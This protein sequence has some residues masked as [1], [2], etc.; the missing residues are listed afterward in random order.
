MTTVIKLCR[1]IIEKSFN[2]DEYIN[3]L[4]ELKKM[5]KEAKN[6]TTLIKATS[7]YF[8]QFMFARFYSDSLFMK[9]NEEVNYKYIASDQSIGVFIC[10]LMAQVGRDN[11]ISSFNIMIDAVLGYLK[12]YNANVAKSGELVSKDIV[13]SILNLPVA[14]D[15]IFL[16]SRK[17]PVL[18]LNI[19][20]TCK[21]NSTSL[22]HLGV[23]VNSRSNPLN[24]DN[25]PDY[26]FMHEMGHLVHVYLTG[27][28][29]EPP[30][31]FC[32]VIKN[33]F[34][35]NINDIPKEALL[36]IFA[37]CFAIGCAFG[38]QYEQ[39]NP[40][41]QLFDEKDIEYIAGYIKTLIKGEIS[42]IEDKQNY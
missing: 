13:E 25:N 40:F 36:E 31:S 4:E 22:P 9:K 37:D 39:S 42:M 6:K 5:V 34:R 16:L 35:N 38:T 11:K 28:L 20:H 32:D 7:D 27:D 21:F 8:S 3:K 30:K 29:T 41:C 12:D 23:I 14:K 26:V 2:L 33:A 17:K 19:N 1:E 15:A 18:I 10:V 24:G